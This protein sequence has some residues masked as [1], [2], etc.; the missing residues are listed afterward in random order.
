MVLID[1]GEAP[2]AED[3]KF[4]PEFGLRMVDRAAVNGVDDDS[5]ANRLLSHVLE[6]HLLILVGRFVAANKD[7]LE[8]P[9]VLRPL[10]LIDRVPA[11]A[12]DVFFAAVGLETEKL[13]IDFV[14]IGGEILVLANPADLGVIAV[15][16]I[17]IK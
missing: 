3:R 8:G 15:V 2:F 4:T 13:F 7:H 14:Q 11:D 12:G 5:P 10:Q 6:M 16:A 1:T 9:F 17:A